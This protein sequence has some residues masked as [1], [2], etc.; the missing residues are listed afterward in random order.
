VQ[1]HRVVEAMSRRYSV[2]YPWSEPS[3]AVAQR[4]DFVARADEVAARGQP[5]VLFVVGQDDE[6]E[7]HESAEQMRAALASRYADPQR[8]RL[9][10]IPGMA[11][12]LAEEPGIEPSP[13]TPAAALVDREAVQWF[14]RY[15]RS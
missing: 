11:H 9:V 15:L 5:A 1:L 3:R 10:A 4:L 14:E 12:A 2:T 13:Q 7:F 6:A 8:T